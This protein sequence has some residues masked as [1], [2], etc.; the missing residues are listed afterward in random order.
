MVA[1][2]SSPLATRLRPFGT[3]IFA[4]MTQLA[5]AH[6]AVNLGQGF[7]N[8]EG[9]AEIKQIAVETVRTG[10]NQYA[11][12]WGDLSLV[13][14]I[15]EHQERFYELTYDPIGEVTVYNGA[16]EAIFASLMAILNPGDEVVIFEPYYDSYRASIA[17]AGGRERIVTLRAPDFS[18]RPAELEAAINERTRCILLNTPHNPSGKV[19]AHAELEH[20]AELARRHDLLIISDEVYEHLVFEG[21]HIPIATLPG[22]RERTI[23]ISSAGK[24]FSFTGWKVGHT[25]APAEITSAL[26][27]SHQFITFCNSGP[28]Q[29]AV[30]AAY[31]LPDEYFATFIREYRARRDLLCGA[32]KSLGLDVLVPAGTYFVTTDIR[33]LGYDNDVEFCR[34]LPERVGVAAIPN[35]AFYEN[36]EEGRH[37][38]RWAFCKTTAML[39]A[40]VERLKT[41]KPMEVT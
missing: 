32:L 23:T 31:R 36:K 21:S 37:L 38:V 29:P 22:M 3:T 7:P 1:S 5:I 15:S 10:N 9:P 14:A 24:S 16:T 40:G 41:L 6:E 17:M 25:C 27:T 13:H 34:M 20:I 19:F 26:R 30:A 18:Y 2:S 39:E 11:R 28:L 8:F 33:P 35:S 12:P 4:E